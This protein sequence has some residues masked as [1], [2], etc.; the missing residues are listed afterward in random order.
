MSNFVKHT[1]ADLKKRYVY[2]K[3]VYFKNPEKNCNMKRNQLQTYINKIPLW[4][5]IPFLKDKCLEIYYLVKS[6]R[7]E[8]LL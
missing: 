4:K 1:D 5:N 8:E 6:E 7:M 3:R 2:K